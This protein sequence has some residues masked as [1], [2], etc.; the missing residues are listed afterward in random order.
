MMEETGKYPFE[1][2]VLNLIILDLNSPWENLYMK[3]NYILF[4][5]IFNSEYFLYLW[6]N[7]ITC[8]S[9][10]NIDDF[11]SNRLHRCFYITVTDVVES[12]KYH[13]LLLLLLN[14]SIL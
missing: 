12:L 5:L 2:G 9:I 11:V 13:L 3:K 14:Y 10:S 6:I 1:T 8:D 4:P 7:T